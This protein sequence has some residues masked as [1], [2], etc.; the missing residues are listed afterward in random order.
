M[1]ESSNAAKAKK[2]R[3]LL[4][5]HTMRRSDREMLASWINGD[6]ALRVGGGEVGSS[7]QSIG[8]KTFQS[9]V[10]DILQVPKE[11]RHLPLVN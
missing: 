5:I 8:K 9:T 1:T 2:K 11:P 10:D 4:D 6:T 7:R 3:I